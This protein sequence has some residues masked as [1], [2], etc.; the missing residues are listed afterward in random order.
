M[1]NNAFEHSN[2]S[3]GVFSCGQHFPNQKKLVLSLV[4]FGEGIVSKV[5]HYLSHTHHSD[6]YYLEWAF[7]EGHTTKNGLGGLGLTL[8]KEFIKINKGKLEVYTNNS[9]G[10]IDQNGEQYQST[11][12]SFKGTFFHISLQCDESLYVF[13]N[14]IESNNFF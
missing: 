11:N 13:A 14:E 9:Y 4:D 6:E 12:F 3:I 2:S 1:Y 10:L 7:Q 8:I 5:H